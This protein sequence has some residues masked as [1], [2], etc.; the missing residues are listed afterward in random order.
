MEYDQIMNARVSVLEAR[1]A[2][3]E[4]R[5]AT[6]EQGSTTTKPKRRRDLSPEDRAAIR[7]RL[8][9]GQEKK[10]K[11]REAA[12][13]AEAKAKKGGKNGTSEAAH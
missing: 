5:L 6:F 7:A 10:R 1:M 11:E 8:V 4:Q 12:A 3:L 2:A 13:V 9:A